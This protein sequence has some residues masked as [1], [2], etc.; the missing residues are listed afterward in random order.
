MNAPRGT[1]DIIWAV[2]A[3]DSASRSADAASSSLQLR[4]GT[5][6]GSQY[7]SIFTEP[8]S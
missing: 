8:R 7:R 6:A 2:T 3:R 4:T 1:S 5:E